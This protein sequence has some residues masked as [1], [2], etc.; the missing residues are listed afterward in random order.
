MFKKR[1]KKSTPDKEK[2]EGTGPHK[3]TMSSSLEGKKEKD[4]NGGKHHGGCEGVNKGPR[5]K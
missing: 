1:V 3:K 4:R 5:V 2:M